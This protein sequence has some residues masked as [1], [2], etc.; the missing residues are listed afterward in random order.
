[1][2]SNPPSAATSFISCV[3]KSN[4]KEASLPKIVTDMMDR[5]VFTSLYALMN[6]HEATLLAQQG[7]AFDT[8]VYLHYTEMVGELGCHY[9]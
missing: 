4:A 3:F 9:M 8:A 5:E 6:T 7:A 2:H 1:M